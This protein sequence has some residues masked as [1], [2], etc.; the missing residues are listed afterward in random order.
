MR[1]CLITL[2]GLLMSVQFAQALRGIEPPLDGP[3]PEAWR[4]AIAR[5]AVEGD[6]GPVDALLAKA[7]FWQVPDAGYGPPKE[8]RAMRVNKPELCV[9][10]RCLILVLNLEGETAKVELLFFAG[11]DVLGGDFGATVD[12]IRAVSLEFS[13]SGYRTDIRETRLGWFIHTEVIPPR[14]PRQP[15]NATEG[16]PVSIIESLRSMS[17]GDG[18]RDR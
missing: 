12:G 2:L 8:R 3:L 7:K 16:P 9:E 18:H 10:D 5:L 11:D 4:I 6:L 1:R 17:R 13:S 15:R 14:P